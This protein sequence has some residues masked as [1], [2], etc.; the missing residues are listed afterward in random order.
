MYSQVMDT[1][2]WP[3]LEEVHYSAYHRAHKNVSISFKTRKKEEEVLGR[4][5]G[6]IWNINIFV[7]RRQSKIFSCYGGRGPQS[8]KMLP[9]M[10]PEQHVGQG[11]CSG[12]HT[13]QSHGGQALVLALPLTVHL[14]QV[15][16]G[17]NG[18]MEKAT[19]MHPLGHHSGDSKVV[20]S[21]TELDSHSGSL[22]HYLSD[23]ISYVA[24]TS[25]SF[26]A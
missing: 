13:P 9:E 15:Y 18:R 10:W 14:G 11:A 17:N 21:Q 6:F 19:D 7:F 25:I 4:D 3:S 1:R 2:I 26:L 23:S 24:F 20:C 22:T 8:K 5:N 16:Q 12:E